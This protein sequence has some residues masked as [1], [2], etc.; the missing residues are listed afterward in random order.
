MI[1]SR[2]YF[3]YIHNNFSE[4]QQTL[5]KITRCSA[6]KRSN[7]ASFWQQDACSYEFYFAWEYETSMAAINAEEEFDFNKGKNLNLSAAFGTKKKNKFLLQRR[8]S[9]DLGWANPWDGS[10]RV[11]QIRLQ[12]EIHPR[13]IIHI[14]DTKT[15]FI[16][17]LFHHR[18]SDKPGEQYKR[19]KSILHKQ[20]IAIAV[21][22][23]CCFSSSFFNYF[24]I[25]RT[26][27]WSLI[28]RERNKIE[29]RSYVGL[30]TTMDLWVLLV[31]D[32]FRP[33]KKGHACLKPLSILCFFFLFYTFF[34][35]FLDSLI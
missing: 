35:S 21:L 27:I 19:M 3:S 7:L 22:F 29:I 2:L 26:R 12:W 5:Q 10:D 1:W 14:I 30:Y 25:N 11:R 31:A 28:E 17:N 13:T 8:I 18:I 6:I 23:F 32:R 9:W 15:S 34:F 4:Y 16:V 20:R 33:H 24:T